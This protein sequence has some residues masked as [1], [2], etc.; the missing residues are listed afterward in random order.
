MVIGMKGITE[1]LSIFV[2]L[3]LT[4]CSLLAQGPTGTTGTNPQSGGGGVSA[5]IAGF[6]EIEC[7]G[8]RFVIQL[9][10]ISS[11][12]QHEYVIDGAFRVNECTVDTSGSVTARFYFIEPTGA[13]SSAVSGSATYERLKSVANRASN[14]AGMGDAEHIVSKNYP[15]TTHAKTSEYR[16]KSKDTIGKIYNHV[17]KVWALEKGRGKA[18][19]ITIR[20]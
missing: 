6:W 14:K 9:N 20:E 4:Q 1:A 13:S 8:G 11:V 10:Q 5:G 2:G 3:V 18:N 7:P 17:H 19:K 15:T 12:S 16:F